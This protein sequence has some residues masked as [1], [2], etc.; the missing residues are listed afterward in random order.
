MSIEG[1][2]ICSGFVANWHP[3]LECR[4]GVLA[5]NTLSVLGGRVLD[6][7]GN[8][9]PS[10]TIVSDSGF[11]YLTGI[12]EDSDN[13]G[14]PDTDDNCPTDQNPSQQD[15]DSD[16]HGDACDD[17]DDNDG[18]LDDIDNCRLDVNPLQLDFDEDGA[19]DACDSDDDNDNV[20][21]N[22]DTCP[23]TLTGEI[24]NVTGCSVNDLC[25]C[26][27]NWKN[28]GAYIQCVAHTG[29]DFV[30]AGMLTEVEKDTIVSIAGMS[31]CGANK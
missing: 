26:E 17:D 14:I 6:L 11:D 27:N 3:E 5:G 16:G 22:V 4:A 15:S 10:V 2:S 19:G 31:S 25:P 30:A 24:V 9:V 13:D 1:T 23:F 29:E 20:A 7:N 8:E 12:T 21:D 18:V 28:Q